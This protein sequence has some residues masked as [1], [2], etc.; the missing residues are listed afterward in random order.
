[1]GR[2]HTQLIEGF[3]D[4]G[5]PRIAFPYRG[6]IMAGESGH[7]YALRMASGNGLTGLLFLKQLL[8]KSHSAVL[9]A[10]DAAHLAQWFGASV[11]LLEFALERIVDGRREHGCAYGGQILGRR[12][13]LSRSYPRVCVDCLKELGYCRMAWDYSITVACVRHRRVLT[14]VCPTCQRQVSWNRPGIAV[15]DCGCA[16]AM[17]CVR[18]AP[19]RF[20]LLLAH[21]V[22]LRM[23]DVL[24]ADWPSVGDD[25]TSGPDIQWAGTLLRN[26]SVDGMMR[27]VHGLCT[28]ALYA[29]AAP[30]IRKRGALDKARQSISSAMALGAR[31]ARGDSIDLGRHRPSVLVDLLSDISASPTATRDDLSVAQSLLRSLISTTSRSTLRSNHASLAQMVLF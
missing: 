29:P 25:P 14:D 6:E 10:D 16:L 3:E 8:G 4:D 11:P 13:F 5:Q 31:L 24:S 30:I 18:Q 19:T 21:L 15:C 9:D 26:L 27:V 23:N 7:G 17:D 22:D 1:M 2:T 12:Y 28:A 20:E